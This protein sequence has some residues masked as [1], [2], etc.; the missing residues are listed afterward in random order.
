MSK[1]TARK[2]MKLN[3]SET[4]YKSL[5]RKRRSKKK[6]T[7]LSKSEKKQLNDA[8]YIKYCKCLKIFESEGETRGYPICMNA[9]YKK[10]KIKPP[11]NASKKCKS[12]FKV[13][14]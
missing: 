6:N 13:T 14:K 11:K 3:I 7:S 12:T 10:R 4:K 5:L 9:V 8:L 2:S 1:K